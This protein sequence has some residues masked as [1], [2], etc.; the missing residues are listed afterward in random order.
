MDRLRTVVDTNTLVSALCF[1]GSVPRR[2]VDRAN[3]DGYFLFSADTFREAQQVLE[4]DRFDRYLTRDERRRFLHALAKKALFVEV[5]ER[6]QASRDPKDDKFLE[7]A[8]AAEAHVI[9]TG[10]R[11]L[12]VLSPFRGIPILEPAAFLQAE[13]LR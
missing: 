1:P 12:L 7:L 9:V 4:R 10:D 3:E 13:L 2:A 11:D 8:V 6:I 5:T